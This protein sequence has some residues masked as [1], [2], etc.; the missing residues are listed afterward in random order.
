MEQKTYKYEFTEVKNPG[1]SFPLQQRGLVDKLTH[2][3]S[4]CH[5]K[6]DESKQERLGLSKIAFELTVARRQHAI[7]TFRCSVGV[8]RRRSTRGGTMAF[9]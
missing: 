6:S 9:N 2:D 1:K 3:N 5:L 7:T 8:R 4:N